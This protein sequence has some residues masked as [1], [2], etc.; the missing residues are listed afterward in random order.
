LAAAEVLELTDLNDIADQR[1][2]KLSGG[3]TQRIRFALARWAYRRD[4]QRA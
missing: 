2:Q 4:T 1:T 3:Q